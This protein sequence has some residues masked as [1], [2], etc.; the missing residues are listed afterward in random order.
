LLRLNDYTELEKASEV[1]DEEEGNDP[2]MK[3][4]NIETVTTVNMQK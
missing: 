1:Q 3:G 2:V 4:G